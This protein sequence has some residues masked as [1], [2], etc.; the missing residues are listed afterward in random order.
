M[1]IHNL[2]DK[3][4]FMT[5][6][7]LTG[8]A[9]SGCS[10]IED[11]LEPCPA[12]LQLQFVFDYNLLQADAFASQVK[13]VNVWAFDKSSGACV[14]S[15]SESGDALARPGYIMVTPLPEGTYDFVVWGGLHDNA[16]FELAT[17]APVSKQELEVKLKTSSSDGLNISSSHFK[18]LF[19]GYIQ[20]V[21]YEVDPQAPSVR[22]VTVP[23]IKDTND[24]AVMLQNI[25]GHSL[26]ADDFTVKFS[27]AD[28]WLAWDNSVMS[29]SPLV[30]Y[31]PW[32]SLY[33]QTTV[34]PLSKAGD[35]DDDNV[36]RTTLLYE[37]SVSRLIK[38]GD[39]YLDVIRN[40]DNKTIIHVPLIEFFL[41]EK[42]NRYN[43]FGE[44]EYLD[45]RDDYSALFFLNDQS[46]W[47]VA[48]GIY[49]NNWVI[50]PPQT[51]NI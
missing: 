27:Y 38:G 34:T 4:R 19:H 29:A 21:N 30:T 8:V 9:L 41:L 47:Y 25:N 20:D 45:R 50:V 36:A 28:S 10:I 39:A 23:L 15:G 3:V 49:I 14:W 48:G 35:E 12:G 13:S 32:S 17:Y 1:L 6:A 24:I 11:D 2:S 5:F 31:T 40:D 33:G 37:I 46:D 43:Q 16:D 51:D 7:C 26:N 22:T 44:Q 42:G 18:G